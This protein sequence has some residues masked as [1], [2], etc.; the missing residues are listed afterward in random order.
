MLFQRSA[1]S[2]RPLK[3]GVTEYEWIMMKKIPHISNQRSVNALIARKFNNKQAIKLVE[4]GYTVSKLKSLSVK[5]LKNLGI[6][7]SQVKEIKNGHRSHIPIKTVSK[8]LYESTFG[9]CICR[10]TNSPVIIHH[11]DKYADSKNHSEDNLVVLCLKHH[12]EAHTKHGL[13][14]NLTPKIIKIAKNEWIKEVKNNAEKSILKQDHGKKLSAGKYQNNVLRIGID[15]YH[16]KAILHF[17]KAVKELGFTHTILDHSPDQNKLNEIDVLL[18]ATSGMNSD[19]SFSPSEIMTIKNFV[20]NGGSL[21]CAD[22]AW[23][24]VYRSYGNKP[25]DAFPL[26]VLGKNL[27]FQIT[28]KNVGAPC[29]YETEIMYGINKVTRKNWWPSQIDFLLGSGQAIIRD[30]NYRIIAGHISLGKGYI[31]IIGHGAMLAEN[32]RLTKNVLKFLSNKP[33]P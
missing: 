1:K 4:D 17:D 20:I 14:Q 6:N 13:S 33:I 25:I 23:S 24:W 15:L 2:A 30:E 11:I 9:C 5:E 8:L 12:D 31:I 22:Q 21:I 18:I 16:G 19:K 32:P 3:I 7:D 26:N 29:F 10:N 28:G 27:G